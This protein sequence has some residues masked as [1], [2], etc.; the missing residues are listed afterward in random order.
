MF[1]SGNLIPYQWLE[2][3]SDEA[4][5]LMQ[6]ND[7]ATKDLPAIFFEDGSIIST[8]AILDVA[9]KIGLSPDVKNEIYDAVVIGPF[10]LS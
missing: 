10:V 6:V 5:Q 3:T 9:R 7:L 4:K 8:P 2:A 1:L